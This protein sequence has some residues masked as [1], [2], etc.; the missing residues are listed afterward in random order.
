MFRKKKITEIENLPHIFLEEH[1]EKCR[2]A[3]MAFCFKIIATKSFKSN[4]IYKLFHVCN[5]EI[6]LSIFDLIP[7]KRFCSHFVH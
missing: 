2:T 4:D 5:N 7:P 1:F 3:K 6:W